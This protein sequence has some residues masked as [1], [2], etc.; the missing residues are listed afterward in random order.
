MREKRRTVVVCGS[1]VTMEKIKE[2]SWWNDRIAV[3]VK[4]KNEV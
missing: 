1:T 4:N 2:I 3:V